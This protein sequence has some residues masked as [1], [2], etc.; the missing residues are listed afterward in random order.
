[1]TR[2]RTLAEDI[3]ACFDA[4]LL[5]DA[6]RAANAEISAIAW[7]GKRLL[8]ASDKPIPGEQRSSVFAREC[9]DGRPQPDTLVY[10]TAPL[11]FGQTT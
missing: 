10:Y 2:A 5:D 8:M 3:F 7:D 4:G 1:M 11:N 9:V 6:G